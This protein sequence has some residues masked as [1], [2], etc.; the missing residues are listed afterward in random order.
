MVCGLSWITSWWFLKTDSFFEF[1][2]ILRCFEHHKPNSSIIFERGWTPTKHVSSHRNI[3][4]TEVWGEICF[5]FSF[6]ILELTVSSSLCEELYTS[7]KN[8]LG[9][10]HYVIDIA[11]NYHWCYPATCHLI[12]QLSPAIFN[13]LWTQLSISC[14][15]EEPEFNAMNRY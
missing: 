10:M 3:K 6:F 14:N 8:R 1:L 7:N 13:C 11:R 12:L 5:C 2:S 15:W 9:Q 4:L